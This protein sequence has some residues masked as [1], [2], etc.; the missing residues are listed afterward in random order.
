MRFGDNGLVRRAGEPTIGF[1]G[2]S[3][4]ARGRARR[5]RS[6]ANPIAS[7]RGRWML[8]AITRAD[9][10]SARCETDQAHGKISV[11]SRMQG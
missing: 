7:F 8:K 1:A 3:D 2:Q 10:L 9:A 4:R 11:L 6:V 5:D